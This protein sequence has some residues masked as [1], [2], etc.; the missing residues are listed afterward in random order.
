MTTALASRPTVSKKP[1]PAAKV[2]AYRSVNPYDGKVVKTFVSLTDARL[3]TALKTAA[4]ASYAAPNAYVSWQQYP[5]FQQVLA[6]NK[7]LRAQRN[8]SVQSELDAVAN[9]FY[10][11]FLV[12]EAKPNGLFARAWLN[13]L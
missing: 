7:M 6:I 1:A 5:L 4:F 12:A 11:A 2:A 10:D 3:E 8:E 13:L 9:L